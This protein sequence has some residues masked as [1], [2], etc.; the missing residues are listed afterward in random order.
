MAAFADPKSPDLT[1]PAAKAP[2]QEAGEVIAEYFRE[3]G[4]H[5]MGYVTL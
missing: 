2:D 3:R 5:K 4:V 1:G